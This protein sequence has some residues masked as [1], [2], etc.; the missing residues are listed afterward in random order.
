MIDQ[1]E[2]EFPTD[3]LEGYSTLMRVKLA[4]RRKQYKD[5]ITQAEQ[6]IKVNPRSNYAPDLLLLEAQAYKAIGKDEQYRKTLNRLIKDYP[7]A[8][9]SAEAKKMLSSK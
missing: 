9:L 1:W 8:P 3:K 7:E 2:N 6:L 4:M 5:A